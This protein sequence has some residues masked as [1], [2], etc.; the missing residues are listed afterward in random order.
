MTCSECSCVDDRAEGWIAVLGQD[1]D[2]PSAPFEM[3]AF[4]P[5]CAAR[6]FELTGRL[7]ETYI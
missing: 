2:D 4:C 3:L 1:P 5:A 6:E 7:A